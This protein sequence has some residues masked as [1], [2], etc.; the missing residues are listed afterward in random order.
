MQNIGL[1]LPRSSYYQSVGFDMS[2]GFKSALKNNN[3]SDLRLVTDNIGFGTDK[4]QVYRTAE[5]MLMDEDTGVVFAYV[6][7]RTAQL[8]RPLFMSAN[9]LLVVLDSGASL[10]QEWPV[11]PNMLYL[12]LHNSLGARL[13]AQRAVHDGFTEAGM[14]TDYFDAG[15]L[16]TIAI[17]NGFVDNGGQI[18]FNVATGYRQEEFSMEPI[19]GHLETYPGSCLLNLFSGDFAEWYFR[20]MKNLFGS[21][22]PP[23]YAAPF[24][25]EEEMLS[26]ALHTGGLTKGVAAW[27]KK[28]TNDENKTFITSVEAMGKNAN[29]FSLLGWEAALMVMNALPEL[30][31]VNYNGTQA[32]EVIKNQTIQTPRGALRFHNELNISVSPMFEAELRANDKGCNALEVTATIHDTQQALEKMTAFDLGETTS[33]WFNSYTCN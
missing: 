25:L 26:R 31:K 29:L 11:S 15:Y 12:S 14:I 27:S 19:R 1:L 17:T 8:L 6:G 9:R 30:E 33:G 10:P 18:S 5:K 2:V 28:L 24:M 4:Q 32:C 13:A 16:H 20:D 7:L 3:C 23:A 22:Q 21:N